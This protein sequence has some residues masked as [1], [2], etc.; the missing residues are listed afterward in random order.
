MNNPRYAAKANRQLPLLGTELATQS[1]V[2][3]TN[4]QQ[5]ELTAALAE[6]LLLNLAGSVDVPKG[7]HDAE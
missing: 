6:L 4:E 2:I 3:L 5:K 7:V 1:P